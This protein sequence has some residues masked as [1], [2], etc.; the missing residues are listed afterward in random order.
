[1]RRRC[2]FRGRAHRTPRHPRVLGRH[3]DRKST[4]PREAPDNSNFRSLPEAADDQ[5]AD[6]DTRCGIRRAGADVP[7]ESLGSHV[8]AGGSTNRGLPRPRSAYPQTAS[9]TKALD[10]FPTDPS[11]PC[12]HQGSRTKPM[13]PTCL[14]D[15]AG[16]SLGFSL[17]SST[18]EDVAARGILGQKVYFR[19]R[20]GRR[21]RQPH[22]HH[23]RSR[24][25]RLG[26]SQ[27]ISVAYADGGAV[28]NRV[29]RTCS[30]HTVERTLER[31]KQQSVFRALQIQADCLPA[32]R[33]ATIEKEVINRP[34]ICGIA[35]G[36]PAAGHT[37]TT[38][39]IIIVVII[40]VSVDH[41]D[42]LRRRIV[43]NVFIGVSRAD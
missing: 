24:I 21:R 22:P 2:F 41:G 7:P 36:I 26:E 4:R 10:T 6:P 12:L 3:R 25:S 15:C 13:R 5:P 42:I 35:I 40:S 19:K 17:T 34:N 37:T 30:S 23:G 31:L 11:N 8:H 16:S 27:G 18:Y 29:V 9:P 33:L 32:Y 14:A 38:T 1:M 39:A 20:A 43:N 28:K